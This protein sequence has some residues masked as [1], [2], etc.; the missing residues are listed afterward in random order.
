MKITLDHNCIINLENRTDIGKAIE[1]IVSDKKN[2]CFV[3]NIGASEM[4]EKGV[5]PDH[6]EKFEELLAAAGISRL[7]R[8]NPMPI[9][10]VTFFDRCILADEDMIKLATAIEDALFSE[11]SRID[12]ASVGLDSPAGGKWLNRLCDVHSMWCHIRNGNEVFLTTDSNFTKATK[13]PRL[14]ALGAGRI[15]HPN[16]L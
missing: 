13:L 16:E 11:A 3:V 1:A 15:S 14:V 9:L 4:R 2:N 7:P 8:L 5:R 12:I 6:Y 10:D